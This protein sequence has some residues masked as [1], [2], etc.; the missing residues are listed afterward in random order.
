[1]IQYRM[2]LMALFI[3][4]C[5][6]AQ[7][8]VTEPDKSPMDMSYSPQGYPV[9]K[10]QSK[11]AAALKPNARVVYSRPQV[12]GRDIFGGEVKYNEVWRVG[13]NE[14]TEIEFYKNATVGGKKVPKGRYSLFCIPTAGSWTLII[15][16]DTDSWGSF[17]YDSTFDLV[18][19]P[20]PV[21]KL[22]SPVEYFTM[23][24]D[25]ANNLVIMWENTKVS[26]PIQFVNT[27]VKVTA[28]NR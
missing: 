17:S 26:L 28:G 15:N 14:S 16:K 24:F 25:S 2:L 19:T 27:N 12:K 5:C 1:M 22:D 9:L 10:F 4:A 13:A 11:G 6:S 23:Y 7:L 20:V 21:Q 8:Q 18:R 3:S